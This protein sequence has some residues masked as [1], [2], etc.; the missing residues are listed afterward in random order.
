MTR[1]SGELRESASLVD[2]ETA[3]TMDTE[4]REVLWGE[5]EGRSNGG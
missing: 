3:A 4:R 2:L 1:R 5:Q